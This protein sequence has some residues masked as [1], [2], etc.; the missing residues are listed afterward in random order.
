MATVVQTNFVELDLTPFD[1]FVTGANF[2]QI[3]DVTTVSLALSPKNVTLSGRG[4][5]T[6]Q[7]QVQSQAE[8]PL[9]P[10]EILLDPNATDNEKALLSWAMDLVAALDLFINDSKN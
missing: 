6:G 3:I 2:I 10:Q 8:I 5:R 7:S 4:I 9:P 1:T